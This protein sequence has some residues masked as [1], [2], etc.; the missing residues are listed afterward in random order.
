MI[1]QT[2]ALALRAKESAAKASRPRSPLGLEEVPTGG[3]KSFEKPFSFNFHIKR[4]T[5]M[6]AAKKTVIALLKSIYW[7]DAFKY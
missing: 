2:C 4:L 1:H 5:R 3:V 6:Y 7:Q